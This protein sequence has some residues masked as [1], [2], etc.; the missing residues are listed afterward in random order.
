MGLALLPTLSLAATN[1]SVDKLGTVDR[2]LADGSV[3]PVPGAEPLVAGFHAGFRWGAVLLALRLVAAA[4]FVRVR[5]REFRSR[6]PDES[7]ET[8]VQV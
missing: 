1:R 4:I 7:R 8:V 5:K 2:T 6:G 3:T